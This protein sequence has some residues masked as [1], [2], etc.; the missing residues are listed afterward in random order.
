MNMTY[1]TGLFFQA[2]LSYFIVCPLLVFTIKVDTF[3]SIYWNFK[4][5]LFCP[6]YP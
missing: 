5:S 6:A 4:S 3:I 1:R 2:L